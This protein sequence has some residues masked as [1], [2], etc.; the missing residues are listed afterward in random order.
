MSR[1]MRWV[2][3]IYPTTCGGCRG[4]VGGLKR[5]AVAR[6]GEAVPNRKRGHPRPGSARGGAGIQMSDLVRQVANLPHLRPEDGRLATCPQKFVFPDD[7]RIA[8]SFASFR[9]GNGPLV[10]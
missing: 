10:G 1:R 6:C 8:P 5:V 2:A 4:S 3:N 7:R 9:D